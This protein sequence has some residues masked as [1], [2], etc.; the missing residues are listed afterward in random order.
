MKKN[1]DF[2]IV[3]IKA[4]CAYI[5]NNYN[6]NYDYYRYG[7]IKFINKIKISIYVI[8]LKNGLITKNKFKI[9]ESLILKNIEDF[10]WLFKTLNDE[11]SKIILIDLLAYRC[12]GYK[13]VKLPLNNNLYWENIKKIEANEDK[14]DYLESGVKNWNLNKIDISF[15][16]Y[17]IK[18]YFMAGSIMNCFVLEQY[19]AVT[20]NKIIEVEPGDIVIDAGACWGDTS[21]YF[22]NKAGIKG[23]VYGYEFI[24]HNMDIFNTNIKLN[25]ELEKRITLVNNAVWNI[26]GLKVF[27][28]DKGPGSIVEIEKFN[29]A[30]GEVLTL[31]I[32][33]LAM[34]EQ[35]GK[36]NFIKMDIEGAELNALK[37]AVSTLNKDKPKLA[38]SIYHNLS[39]FYT[40][41]QFID[42]LNIGYKFIIRHFTINAEETVLFAWVD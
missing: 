10:D 41:P 2:L 16:N 1:Q 27:Y 8:L 21:L 25:P 36:I 28:Q 22:A 14:N 6:D 39:D 37:G 5:E 7:K 13:H 29:N 20:E 30:T 40:I 26:S 12:L 42:S 35:I 15:L 18:G 19:K 11:E 23:K 33:D 31:S 17:P 24:P 38:I 3:F 34:K 32:D 9:I 4:I